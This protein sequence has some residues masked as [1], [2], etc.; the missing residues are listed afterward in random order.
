LIT[1]DEGAIRHE[2]LVPV[3]ERRVKGRERER[4]QYTHTHTHRER[5]REL[6]KEF[7]E[8]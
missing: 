8:F 2:T 1:D 3:R 6:F 7:K 4:A 5:E